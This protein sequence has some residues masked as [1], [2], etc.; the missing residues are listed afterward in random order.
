M[1]QPSDQCTQI[2]NDLRHF[3][4]LSEEDVAIVAPYFECR[5][6]RAGEVLWKEGELAGFAAL[7][8]SG[9]IE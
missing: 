1:Q 9:R 2:K 4:F 3:R 5:Q 8:M 7:V 6:V